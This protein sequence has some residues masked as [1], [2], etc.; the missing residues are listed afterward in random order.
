MASSRIVMVFADANG[1]NVTFSYSYAKSNPST[2]NVKN[3]VN[4][5]ITNGDIFVHPPVSAKS[6]KVVITSEN[7]VNLSE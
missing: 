4:G 6:A 7:V 2:S 3:L 5:L 1:A